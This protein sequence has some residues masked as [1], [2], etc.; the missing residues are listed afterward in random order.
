M[1]PSAPTR[2]GAFIAPFHGLRGNPTLQLRRD[3]ELAVLLDELGYDE[4]WFGE[5]HSGGYETIASPEL[6]I[7]AA[8]ER[9][10]RIR[11]GTGVNSLSYHHPY[12]L[13]DRIMQLDHL[14]MGRAMLGVG[15]GQLP[16]DAF[17]LGI[18]PRHQRD[19]MIEAAEVIVP[20]LRG[21]VVSRRTDWFTLD[22]ARLQLR[23][24]TPEGI[25][26]AVASTSSPTGAVLAGR[27]GLSMLALAATDP[28]GF[29]ALDANWRHFEQTA[30]E[31]GNPIDRSRWRV[32]AAMHLAETREEAEHEVEHG[33]LTLCGYMEGMGNTKLPWT[34]SPQ[35]ALRHWTTHG[36]PV[37]GVA[38][39][40]TP[41]DAIATI[42]RL[43]AKTGGFGTFLFLAHNCATWEATKHSYRLFAEYVIPA[44]RSMNEG[45]A[46][47]IR[48]VGQNSARFFGAML[49][50][51]QQAIEK[52]GRPANAD[53]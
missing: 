1:T 26:V 25:E 41:D 5:H 52:Y 31:H 16:S 11:L 3:L 24:S 33:V 4:V 37:F 36:Y 17:M 34:G 21:E 9:T 44:C 12:I 30:T 35:E 39:V 13:A 29:D 8:A 42:Q 23:A 32:V 22:E 6:M 51:T 27:L 38:T 43:S 14:T 48:W 2:F 18:D 20:L 10:K 46:D 19:M 50:A 49:Q 28:T 45:R 53:T 7:A 40:G 15:P 47:S